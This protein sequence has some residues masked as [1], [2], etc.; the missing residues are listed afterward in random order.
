[1][2]S[3]LKLSFFTEPHSPQSLLLFRSFGPYATILPTAGKGFSIC[4]IDLPNRSQGDVQ[5]SFDE[6][7]GNKL[8]FF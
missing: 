1:M 8:G 2:V 7:G 5:V 6:S 4:W 3:V